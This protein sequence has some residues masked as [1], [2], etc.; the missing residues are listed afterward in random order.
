MAV[1]AIWRQGMYLECLEVHKIAPGCALAK[2][3]Q[4]KLFLHELRINVVVV[5]AAKESQKL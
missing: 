5:V 3:G 4:E 2:L 1:G